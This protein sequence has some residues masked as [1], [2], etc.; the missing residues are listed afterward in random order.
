MYFF[1]LT[2]ASVD[3]CEVHPKKLSKLAGSVD[4]GSQN[5]EPATIFNT[6]VIWRRGLFC[7]PFQCVCVHNLYDIINLL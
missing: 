1:H 6:F 3:L 4:S 7:A 2:T 5:K